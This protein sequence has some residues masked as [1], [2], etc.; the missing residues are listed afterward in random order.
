VLGASARAV[1]DYVL[2]PEGLG[3]PAGQLLDLFDDAAAA[4]KQCENIEAF[5]TGDAVRTA[6]DLIVYYV[7]H[8]G[9]DGDEYYLAVRD[10]AN[11]REFLTAI[12]SRK[13]ARIIHEAF[14]RRRVYVILDACFAG[15]AAS[16]WQ[17][18]ALE[19]AV[20]RMSRPFPKHGTAFLAAASKDDVAIAPRSGT[21]TMFT[22]ALLGSLQRGLPG[23]EMRLSLYE[24]YE[25]IRDA[26]IELNEVEGPRPELHA[27]RQDD[28]DI[29]L[30]PLFPNA[31]HRAAMIGEV[32]K[33]FKITGRLGKGGMGEVWVAEQQLVRTKVAIKLLLADISSDRQLVQRFFNEAVAVSRIKH[34]GI[35]KISDVGFHKGSAYL[36]MEL[37]EGESLAS[38]IRRLGRLP[39]DQV[40]EVGRQIASVMDATHVA[41]ITHRDLKPDNI[42]LIPD[43]E[44]ASG[45]RVKILDFGIAKLG[46]AVNLTGA[47][48]MMGTPSY[49]APEQ[50]TDAA[51]V[52]ARADV[53][54][55]GCIAFEMCC[56][57][58][59]FVAASLPEA[60]AMHTTGTPPRARTLVPK[61]P[62]E[63]DDLIAAALAKR[64]GARPSMKE[65]Q[66]VFAAVAAAPPTEPDD[67]R[68]TNPVLR[69]PVA[70]D[71]TL[72]NAI[73]SGRAPDPAPQP[74]L[75]TAAIA[76]VGAIGF[77]ALVYFVAAHVF[78]PH[79]GVRDAGAVEPARTIDAAVDAAVDASPDAESA[80]D[81]LLR[82]NPFQ[83]HGRVSIQAHV[84]TR[85]E[86]A[87]VQV[88]PAPVS[89][90]NLA[91]QVHAYQDAV[92][93]CSA[94]DARLPGGNE[95]PI[96]IDMS[97]NVL[98]WG[99]KLDNGLVLICNKVS[100][101]YSEDL[102]ADVKN[103]G[104]QCVK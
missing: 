72:R 51:T 47:G 73:S 44:L 41:D 15:S 68:P 81:R 26:L 75:R 45:E 1:R 76:G 53:Y 89:D 97:P 82:V 52:D 74:W 5:L 17:G 90:P 79:V 6:R 38:R 93:F 20:K 25:L 31:S 3:I 12:E 8:G 42:F 100:S 61:L 24:L 65:L 104:V 67:T 57:R 4:A 103:V 80:R 19:W 28:G 7:G 10:T 46:T 64:P 78:G 11:N 69:P 92:A 102:T 9:F 60:F 49:M 39:I 98:V 88:S 83:P 21:Y 84:V 58:P 91:M 96:I 35:A 16:D 62:T 56:G 2:S 87:L 37:L 27:P 71:S 101:S 48:R 14:G 29:S 32:I 13:L 95:C 55:V 59:P 86:F 40:A 34:S 23:G 63:L 70:P 36:I 85:E 33:D 54:S 30:L 77:A 18:T 66:R 94:L 43:L 99:E 22:G 50:W